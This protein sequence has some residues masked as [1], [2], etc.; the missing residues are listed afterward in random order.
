MSASQD[1]IRVRIAGD[2]ADIRKA[3]KDLRRETAASGKEARSSG[4]GWRQLGN[5]MDSVRRQVIGIVGA[6]VGL[7]AVGAVFRSIIRNTV[8]AEEVTAQLEAR[9][10]STGGAAGFTTEQLLDM[11]SGLQDVTTF[12][13]EAIATMESVLL[14]FTQIRGGVFREATEVILDMS[15]ALNTDLKAAALQVGKA[16]NDP[17]RGVSALAE[18]GIQF[19]EQQRDLIRNLVETGDVA[20]AQAVILEE[21]QTQ[22]GGAARAARDTFGGAI[23][24]LKNAFG[25]LLEGR[26][27]SVE[28]ARFQIEALIV[29]MKDP[30]TVAAFTNLVRGV[31]TAADFLVN[32]TIKFTQAGQSLGEFV[33]RASGVDDAEDNF[34]IMDAAISR[35]SREI[36][37]LR[38]KLETAPVSFFGDKV[39]EARADLE[40]LDRQLVELIKSRDALAADRR[41]GT[42]GLLT[43]SDSAA[44]DEPPEII[45]TVI[46]VDPR[47]AIRDLQSQLSAAGVLLTDELK[48]LGETLDR[49]FEDNLL[50][51]SDYYR[52]RAEL[53]TQA[54]DQQLSE[55]RAALDL[56][57]EEIR[58]AEQRGDDIEEQEAKRAALIAEITV[59]ER[60]RAEVAERAA[61]AQAR[62]EEDLAE[63]L[64]RVRQRLLELQGDSVGARTAELEREFGELLERLQIEGDAAGEALVRQIIDIELART[65]LSEFESEYKRTLT[66]LARAERRVETEITAGVISER[67]GR[68]Q[69]IA[70]HEEAARKVEALI[71]VMRE[72]AEATGDPA[73]LERLKNLELELES[74]S[75]TAEVVGREIRES[76][77]DSAEDAFSSFLDGTQ[78]AKDAFDSF[79]QNIRSKIADL[80]AERLLEKLFG[81][82]GGGN[83]D[84]GGGNILARLFHAGGLVGQDGQALKVPAIAFA[85]APRLHSGGIPGLGPNEVPAILERGEAVVSRRD[86]QRGGLGGVT[87]NIQANDIRSFERASRGQIAA[88]VANELAK[89]RNRGG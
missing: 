46:S 20:G 68:R 85:G 55:R 64:D 33:A 40:R 4:A 39:E 13:D 24:A 36:D 31:L 17:I 50:R 27:G 15:I 23:E 88:G 10:Q 5:T 73:A 61:Y 26:G 34:A 49:D 66:E 25:D 48:R 41:R 51:F 80:L 45:S 43:D 74:L 71:P 53:E 59:L 29:L 7:R 82:T 16:L 63:Q 30:Q 57:D 79:I 89:A 54:A 84:Q 67:E 32:A 28:D 83:Q 44:D 69:I 9:V 65:R 18:A 35:T 37:G 19:N 76:L 77:K 3:I 38:R 6:Y 14:T 22:F 81:L 78:S 70:L 47:R 62:A 12:G 42:G 56:I 1:D 87:V 8:E 52:R 58:L 72:L 60:E 11:A 86:V 75:E 21:L 2:L